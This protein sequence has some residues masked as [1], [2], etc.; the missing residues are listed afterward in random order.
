M[1]DVEF[2]VEERPPL[3][4][5]DPS[6]KRPAQAA[7]RF[8]LDAVEEGLLAEGGRAHDRRRTGSTRSFTRSSTPTFEYEV[9]TRG[10]AAS[11]GAARGAIAFTAAGG[12]RA[13]Q[14][15]ART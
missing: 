15:P 10:V 9:L 3:P 4:A 11:P 14:P 7:V 5:A 6:A 1:Q 12:R 13:V 2:T 8:A